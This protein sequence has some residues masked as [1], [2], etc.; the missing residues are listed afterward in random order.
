MARGAT[1]HRR[2]GAAAFALAWGLVAGFVAVFADVA[3]AAGAGS[4]EKLDDPF[5]IT[6]DRIDYDGRRDLYVAT[7]R[8]RVRQVDRELRA[9][10]VA[11]STATRIGVAQGAVELVDAGDLLDAEFMVFDVDTLRGMLFEGGL[12]AGSEGF[13]V[14]AAELIRTG[15]NTFTV[16][17]GVFTTCRCPDEGRVPWQIR[18]EDADIELGDYGTVRNA[19]FDVLGVPVLWVPWAF[20]PVKSDRETGLLLPKI[21]LGGRSGAGAGLPFFWAAHPQVNVIVTPWVYSERGFKA[22]G[23]IEYVFGERSEGELFVSGLHDRKHEPSG[24][25]EDA[26]WGLRWRHDH[27]LPAE[28][29]WQTDLNL[30]AD[31]FY[32]DDFEEFRDYRRDRFLESTTRLGRAFG[33]S[34]GYG[35]MLGARFADDIQGLQVPGDDFVDSDDFVLQRFAEVRGDVQPGT[36]PQPLGLDLR[37]DSELIHFR[38]LRSHED[39]FQEQGLE[40]RV[41]NGHFYDIG[42]DGQPGGP[43]TAGEGDGIFQPGE[44]IGERGSRLI[45]HPRL[46]RSFRLGRWAE[47]V[48]EIGWQQTLYSTDQQA[49]ARR[50]LLTSRIEL[51][52]RLARDFTREGGGGLRHVIE[53]RLGWAL[54]TQQ[55]QD[56]NP[57]FVPEGSVNQSRLRA[58]T[59]D[60]VTRDPSDRTPASNRVV[61]GVAQ[62]FYGRRASG[63]PLRLQGD[64]QTA[65]D[66]D[67]ENDGL[68]NLYLDARLIGIGPFAARLASSF[69]LET[70]VLDE[71][72]VELGFRQETGW[73]VLRELRING[74]YRYRSRIPT[75]L[76]SNRGSGRINQTDV[77]NQIDL[78]TV[79]LLTRRVQL[80]YA[81]VYKLGGD[82]EF[83]RNQGTVAYVSKC[84][85]WSIGA[86]VAYD[87]REQ[88]SGGLQ[89]RFMGLGDG[90]EDLFGGGLGTGVSF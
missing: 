74:G 5:E 65:V 88:I 44:A 62:R 48:P 55:D 15:E 37:I 89:I 46:A 26:R 51:R 27:W 57:L 82:N 4:R 56:R 16:R 75:F 73:P 49:F 85:C 23:E 22:D 21:E 40:T 39:I 70:E 61:L 60:N 52:G 11:F 19:T 30:V 41:T 67:F 66:W 28:W 12:D 2:L 64:V 69:N 90:G 53:P 43:L 87:R 59:L 78:R 72:R 81:T 77:I 31:N 17:D 25:T 83:L 33:A 6:A 38:S 8:V 34:G 18:T 71:G 79:M 7:G 47:V 1:S 9:E 3:G 20:F 84:R 68:G 35:V 50:G 76:E 54:V 63:G 86:T 24:A 32:S 42:I 14:R 45:V 58:L 29:R 13:K 10:W 36:L 80:D